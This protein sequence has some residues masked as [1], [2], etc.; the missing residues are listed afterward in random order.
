MTHD[1]RIAAFVRQF[2][3]DLLQLSILLAAL[4][5]SFQNLSGCR[6][7]IFIGS[8]PFYAHALLHELRN[9]NNIY[10]PHCVALYILRWQAVRYST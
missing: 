4:W 9:T 5:N 2:G 3:C 8:L 6:I 10:H 1:R 7:Q